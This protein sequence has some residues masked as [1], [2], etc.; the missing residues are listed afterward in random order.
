MAW[1]NIEEK[2]KN[3]LTVRVA[4]RAGTIWLPDHHLSIDDWLT[5]IAETDEELKELDLPR[6]RFLHNRWPIDNLVE[7]EWDDE[8][9]NRRV[10]T[11]MCVGSRAYILFSD[12]SE[13][14]VIAAIEPKHQ[15][16]MYRAVI[17]KLL[18]NP[19]FVRG[20]PDRIRNCR[21]DLLRGEL[22]SWDDEREEAAAPAPAKP[23]ERWKS[24]LS[25]ILGGWIEKW[26]KPPEQV[27]W[28]EDVPQSI[29]KKGSEQKKAS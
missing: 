27:F 22:C 9:S 23:S 15:P 20:R 11:E 6:V 13:Y 5:S 12:W 2:L 7:L 10:I 19:S 18:Q 14:Q 16:S 8:F 3:P 25:E 17:A 26:L 21:P 28:T 1:E 24:F 29:S 4:F